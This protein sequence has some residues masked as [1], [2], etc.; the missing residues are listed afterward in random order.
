MA[1]DVSEGTR[2]DTLRVIRELSAIAAMFAEVEDLEG[3]ARPLETVLD[4]LLTVEYDAF[5]LWDF[6]EKRLRCVFSRGFT[7][8]ERRLA[9]AT[10]M[11]RHP[12]RVFR[13]RT[14]LHVAD[15][16]ADPNHRSKTSPG[17]R[18]KVRSR[19]FIPV[20][21]G[22][23]SLGSF[24]LASPR[25][26][27]FTAEHVAV[28]EFVCRLTGVF[29]RQYIDREERRE[30]ERQLASTARRLQL[31]IS[32]L[33]IALVL[34]DPRGDIELAEG[35]ALG[36]LGEGEEA[37]S[38]APGRRACLV[39]ASADVVLGD[40]TLASLLRPAGD[41]KELV[42]QLGE[43]ALGIRAFARDDGG[44]TLVLED[45]SERQRNLQRLRALNDELRQAR[46]VAVEATRAKSRFLA[47]M[48]HELR[49]PLN[50]I[51]GYGEM[52][53]EDAH[54]DLLDL[55]TIDTDLDR[56]IHSA[57]HL[58]ML[59]NDILDLSK[60]EAGKFTLQPTRVDLRALLDDTRASMLPLCRRSGNRFAIRAPRALAPIVTDEVALSRVLTNLL[61]N[62]NKFT[63]GGEVT[64]EVR[65]ARASTGRLHFA[66]RDTGIGMAEHELTRIFA[67]FTQVDT[68]ST[69][70]FGGTGLGLTITRE[71]VEAL[72]GEIDVSSEPG[73]GSIFSFW[74]CALEQREA[75]PPADRGPAA[76]RREA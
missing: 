76:A 71:L 24:G 42:R 25:P 15:T 70:R 22:E 62:A 44:A 2:H 61:S 34:V 1:D 4:R 6:R 10:A 16:E 52:L 8:E 63:E 23:Q 73:V 35:A 53:L 67:A 68:S 32:S 48:S 65:D 54:G 60:I 26:N 66:V 40:V 18:F 27:A 5:Y 55:A 9:E 11:D 36:L 75:S 74:I 14:I 28:L 50:V 3:L 64:L 57:K 19:L 20:T 58:L 45:I 47:T 7:E 51:I 29:Y 59:I 39:G 17:R 37:A 13:E 46:D 33:P 56:I 38:E 30:T 31:V 43:R 12:G 69:R 49:T 21:Y 41:S 72:G